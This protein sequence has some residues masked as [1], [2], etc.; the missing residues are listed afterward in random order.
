MGQ[1]QSSDFDA[2]T[3]GHDAIFSEGWTVR[4]EIPW[5]PMIRGEGRTGFA[6]TNEDNDAITTNLTADILVPD[7]MISGFL[8]HLPWSN[9]RDFDILG[10]LKS[11]KEVFIRRVNAYQNVRNNDTEG[12]HDAIAMVPIPRVDRFTHIR[13]RGV[14]GRIHYMGMGWSAS[15]TA[16][17]A[18]S[19]FVSSRNIMG[20]AI[21]VGYNYPAPQ[22]WT[23]ANFNRRDGRGTHF[24]WKDDQKN[25]IRGETI[26]DDTMFFNN[27]VLSLGDTKLSGNKDEWIR[28]LSNPDD[29]GSYNKGLAGKNL[30]ARDRLWVANRDILNE[31]DNLNSKIMSKDEILSFIKSNIPSQAAAANLEGYIATMGYDAAGNDITWFLDNASFPNCKTEC[32]NQPNCKGF[33][34]S[35]GSYPDKPGTCYIKSNVSNKTPNGGW[36]LFEKKI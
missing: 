22:D 30:W 1:T 26:V 7:S 18:E 25:Y 10:V 8:I 14:R 24:D 9:C 13:I 16:S 20:S 15:I 12:Y 5:D 6:H 34:F 19:G 29:L 2:F 17:G 11:G 27:G 32:D 35:A 33:N 28:L 36:N 31:L 21:N 23:G 4:G 3:N